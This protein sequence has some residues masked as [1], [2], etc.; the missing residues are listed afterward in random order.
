V[1]GPEFVHANGHRLALWEQAGEGPPIVFAHATGFHAH[2]WSQTIA[3]LPGRQCYALD[4]LGH[5]ES[6]KPAPPYRWRWFG[7]DIAAV[8][9]QRAVRGAIGAGHSMGG[10][11]VP[12]AA[13][14]APEVFS[15]LLLIDPVIRPE[16]QYARPWT[17]SHFAR[18][19]RNRW[20]SAA[21]MFE[22][23]AAREPFRFWDP[24]VLRDYSNRALLPAPDGDG[25]V[26]ACPPDVEGSIYEHSTV[27]DTN[28][29]PEI[30][31][32]A[33]PVTVMR[34]ARDFE[35]GRVEMGASPTAIDLAA[36]F[37]QGRDVKVNYSHFIPMEAP[38]LIA[39]MLR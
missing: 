18:K 17:H 21:E 16:S 30:R 31:T 38:G 32:V 3:Q 4:F 2:I 11:A 15:S 29:Y 26:L 25:F 1:T 27:P 34:S 6:D 36:Q 39:D 33:V 12:L 19:R 28:I 14:L 23:F 35:P 24:E 37:R 8:F 7:E 9:E 20:T 5:G 10:H 13:A 22:S